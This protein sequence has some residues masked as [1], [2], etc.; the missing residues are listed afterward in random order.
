MNKINIE[1]IVKK[2]LLLVPLVLLIQACGDTEIGSEDEITVPVSVSEIKLKSIEEFIDATGTVN[3][4]KEVTQYAEI[5]GF[6]K[7]LKNPRTGKPY[8]LG[9]AVKSGE[10][11]IKLSDPEFENQT[12]IELRKLQLEQTKSEYEKQKS[13][14][15]KGGVTLI[16]LKTAELNY[17]EQEY[18]YENAQ[19]QLEKMDVKAR[20]DGVIV[21]LP[22]YTENVRVN[23]GTPLIRLMNYKKL[24][25]E[26]NLPE[27]QLSQVEVKQ[28]ARIMNYTLTDD[29]LD[30]H[31]TQIS[32]AIETG[33]RTFKTTLSIDNP[34]RVLRPGMF[35]KAEI[36][37][38][39]KDSAIV[40]PKDVVLSRQRG[41]TVYVVVK[42]ASE[43]RV[44]S[45]GL[46]NPS[47]I[48]VTKGLK[49]NERLVTKGFETLR[50]RQKVKIIK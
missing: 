41:K 19:L 21:D 38:A 18:T 28:N 45:T 29:T 9:D 25:L 2:L 8:K 26:V 7:L 44:I 4:S 23:Q 12:R 35:V 36:I 43:E 33:T 20:F 31:I 27:K 48:E 14:Y 42:G 6:Y 47:E 3:S 30:A 34:D 1:V 32:P 11:I 16:E 40:I 24:I 37:V 50:N 5:S 15:D 46:E 49:K 22:Y 17:L 13:L 10:K 39:K